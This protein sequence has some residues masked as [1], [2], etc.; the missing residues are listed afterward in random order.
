[1]H[2]VMDEA[3]QE[4]PLHHRTGHYLLILPSCSCGLLSLPKGAGLWKQEKEVPAREAR[5]LAILVY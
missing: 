3:L 2:A 1:M 4:L 5:L